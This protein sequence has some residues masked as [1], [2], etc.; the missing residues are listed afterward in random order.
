VPRTSLLQKA[1]NEVN[2]EEYYPN[3]KECKYWFNIIN[4]ELFDDELEP[5][6]E[7]KVERLHKKWA[8]YVGD[9]NTQYTII[10]FKPIFKSRR[11]FLEIFSHELIHHYQFTFNIPGRWHGKSFW[12]WGRVFEKKGIRLAIDY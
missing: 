10:R 3:E 9:E 11:F 1:M 4:N 6:S 8:E 12:W 5:V 2:Q 7:F